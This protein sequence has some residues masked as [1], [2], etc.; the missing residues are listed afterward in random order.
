MSKVTDIERQ[1]LRDHFAALA[2][3]AMTS[4]EGAYSVARRDQRYDEKNW[5]KVV[6][7]NAYAM[8]E[9]M[10]VERERTDH[11]RPVL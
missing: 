1:H 8:A 7:A 9:A 3:Q 11:E 4:G 2:M 5:S 6:A 10:L